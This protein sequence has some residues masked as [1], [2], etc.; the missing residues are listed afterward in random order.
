MFPHW[1]PI[2]MSP[3]FLPNPFGDRDTVICSPG[4]S[5][6]VSEEQT[7]CSELFLSRRRYFRTCIWRQRYRKSIVVQTRLARCGS[8][9]KVYDGQLTRETL[10]ISRTID[11]CKKRSFSYRPVVNVHIVFDTEYYENSWTRSLPSR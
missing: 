6:K 7:I 5:T 2:M 10:S 9:R 11:H 8:R 1:K 4:G 3:V